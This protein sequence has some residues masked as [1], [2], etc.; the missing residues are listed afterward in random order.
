LVTS[1]SVLLPVNLEQELLPCVICGRTFLPAPLTKHIKVCERNATRKRKVFDSLKQRVEGTDLAPF[2]QK[3]YL[4]KND[5]VTLPTSE[6]RQS[7][8]KEKH[9]ELVNA[10][11][12]AKGTSTS[13]M[14]STLG[15]RSSTTLGTPTHERCPSCDRQFG[16]KAFDRHV[17]WCK[18]KKTTIHKSPAS[19]LLAK[20][21]LEARTKYKVPPLTKSR[22][23]L[24]REKYS[25]QTN[26]RSDAIVNAKS[27]SACTLDRSPSVRR[28][29]NPLNGR[30]S[31]D[32]MADGG[33]GQV[34][35]N[36][37]KVVKEKVEKNVA[38]SALK[39]VQSEKTLTKE[40]KKGGEPVKSSIKRLI[41]SKINTISVNDD[42]EGL[43]VSSLSL[44][45]NDSKKLVTWKD[46]VK[47]SKSDYA[48]IT[49]TRN[50]DET[51][52]V[53]KSKI[54]RD[55][56]DLSSKDVQL[57]TFSNIAQQSKIKKADSNFKVVVKDKKSGDVNGEKKRQN[58][59]S[60]K[61][62]LGQ[63]PSASKSILPVLKLDNKQAKVISKSGSRSIIKNPSKR[64]P[65]GG[66]PSKCLPPRANHKMGR[67]PSLEDLSL[68]LDTNE[69]Y[70]AQDDDTLSLVTLPTLQMDDLDSRLLL[71][72][73]HADELLVLSNNF[74]P[75]GPIPRYSEDMV[76]KDSDEA[77][78][79]E[80]S[81]LDDH[82]MEYYQNELS[83]LKHHLNSLEGDF[84]LSYKDDFSEGL[85]ANGG[86]HAHTKKKGSKSRSDS[87]KGSPNRKG[88]KSGTNSP[89]I[90]LRKSPNRTELKRN[91]KGSMD[92]SISRTSRG[93]SPASYKSRNSS[94]SPKPAVKKFESKDHDMIPNKY[95]TSNR[96]P[97][98]I[99]RKQ[100]LTFIMNYQAQKTCG[101]RKSSG[102][103][104]SSNKQSF[105]SSSEVILTKK[106]FVKMKAPTNKET[107]APRSSSAIPKSS[108]NYKSRD[109]KALG[110][111]E[112]SPN[113]GK[114]V[115]K[116]SAKTTI[117]AAIKREK[118][119]KFI[120]DCLAQLSNLS[121]SMKSKP[122]SKPNSPKS[123]REAKIFR[124]KYN[125]DN[126]VTQY[127]T[128][129]AQVKDRK[130]EKVHSDDVGVNCLTKFR[131]VNKIINCERF[132]E[133]NKLVSMS[134][135]AS[136]SS[137]E[138]TD[139]F[140]FPDRL[141]S[142]QCCQTSS[143]EGVVKTTIEQRDLEVKTYVD[144]AVDL[145]EDLKQSLEGLGI[146]ETYF[147]SLDDS[148][149]SAGSDVF[150]Q[151]KFWVRLW[152]HQ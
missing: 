76:Y 57:E 144:D 27:V 117:N 73:N 7:K 148:S 15:K 56:S 23:A 62:R 20:E 19:V 21:R 31:A 99:D 146:K 81:E 33:S 82:Q 51:R 32:R 121:K 37:E 47:G 140:S 6:T 110:S 46:T 36:V 94:K 85:E 142:D 90:Q 126:I 60:K 65:A 109:V 61:S 77:I 25:P 132:L 12:A 72:D 58:S 84:Y 74:G 149:D 1:C 41:F 80:K 42:I 83:S 66:K 13:S 88:C 35:H 70:L 108:G 147:D 4:K 128:L 26:S 67:V 114:K 113:G 133:R 130:L 131:R 29:E 43:T 122:T 115:S 55:K 53:V 139:T 30:K 78:L 16:P 101:S 39:V 96:S 63:S 118:N 151:G 8:W 2:H 116:S 143:I 24:N 104:T 103:K 54:N 112:N 17:E 119:S 124:A 91:S 69:E 98:E 107:R 93:S 127:E 34:E 48:P 120:D 45:E 5:A 38:D 145:V 71:G 49:K 152:D 79:D 44:G 28:S 40:A 52:P 129:K 102:K 111:G 18:E 11:R 135:Q 86:K 75:D 68:D 95:R 136:P 3:S 141:V 105:R 123:T 14:P 89:K 50:L 97:R 92:Q 100:A 10:I 106:Q 134:L 137:S 59:I 22:R 150:Q 87:L 138:D 64:L 9:I 125:D